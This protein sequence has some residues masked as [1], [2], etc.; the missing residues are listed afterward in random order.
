MGAVTPSMKRAFDEL[1]AAQAAFRRALARCNW[2]EP[3]DLLFLPSR[4][5]YGDVEALAGRD[6]WPPSIVPR[7][8]RSE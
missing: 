1:D 2:L 6:E 7:D 3:E 4:L 8:H 5:L